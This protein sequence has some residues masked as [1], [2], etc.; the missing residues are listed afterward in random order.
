MIYKLIEVFNMETIDLSSST[1]YSLD[2]VEVAISTSRV[3]PT[4][5]PV[6]LGINFAD[7][8]I[9]SYSIKGYYNNGSSLIPITLEQCTGDHF[10]MLPNAQLFY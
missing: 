6:M 1:T 8:N 9:N 7:Q 10:S 3:D 4:K 5:Q 2:P